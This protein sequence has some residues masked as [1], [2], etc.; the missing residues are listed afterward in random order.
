MKIN[1]KKYRDRNNENSVLIKSQ[2]KI[3]NT[4]MIQSISDDHRRYWQNKFKKIRPD[5]N[6]FKNIKQLSS[7]KSMCAM[8]VTIFNESKSQSFVS[9]DEKC[10]AFSTH[11]AAA[12][13][14]TFHNQKWKKIAS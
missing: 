2:L 3:L 9:D 6:L 14:L 12:H 5:N 1:E 13:E 10:N 4:S 8:P 11:F 7:Y